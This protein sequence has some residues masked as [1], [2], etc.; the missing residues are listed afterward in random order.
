MSETPPTPNPI[1]GYW[2]ASTSV[3]CAVAFDFKADATYRESSACTLTDGS[4]GLQVAAGTFSALA[5]TVT[6]T[7]DE[8]SCVGWSKVSAAN[9]SISGAQL[10]LSDSSTAILLTRMTASGSGVGT[11]GCFANGVFT[12]SPLAPL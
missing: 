12:A 3:S 9:Y 11:Y 7:A 4:V 5:G 1:V 8:A 6:L 2:E 10:T